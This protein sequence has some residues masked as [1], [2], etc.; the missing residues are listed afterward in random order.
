MLFLGT[1]FQYLA[2]RLNCVM[3]PALGFDIARARHMIASEMSTRS[4]AKYTHRMVHLRNVVACI[5]SGLGLF[6]IVSAS[7]AL[8]FILGVLTMLLFA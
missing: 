4:C 2:A 8:K 7:P 6:S 1:P 5:P 3:C